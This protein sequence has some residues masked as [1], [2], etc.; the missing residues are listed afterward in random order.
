MDETGFAVGASQSTRVLIDLRD[1]A[2]WKGVNGRCEWITAIE[3]ANANGHAISPLRIYKAKYTNS[4]WI[5]TQ[6]PS[7]WR[8]S[9]SNSGWTSHSHAFEWI[10]T[11]F[12]PM[13]R[14]EDSFQR[15]R[16]TMNGH[17][18]HMTATFIGFAMNHSID[19]M[20]LPPHCTHV[21][22]PL[23][24][25]IFGPLK[26][27]LAVETDAAARLDPGRIPRIE[28]T[29]M[30]IRARVEAFFKGQYRR[31]WEKCWVGALGADEDAREAPCGGCSI[32]PTTSYT[33]RFCELGPAI[34]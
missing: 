25:S 7:N 19:L 16:L 23:N 11:V 4:A 3:C 5:P 6:I 30:Y 15:R 28:W 10:S 17:S 27:A 12:E 21:L 13:T 1:D 24:I 29:E 32:Q 31:W 9:T 8:F 20:V 26:R 22:Q 33:T 2:S 34:A 18:S 14:P